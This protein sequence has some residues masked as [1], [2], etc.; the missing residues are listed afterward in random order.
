MARTKACAHSFV[1]HLILV[2]RHYG[3]RKNIH[4]DCHIFPNSISTKYFFPNFVLKKYKFVQFYPYK[5][6]FSILSLRNINLTYFCHLIKK[7]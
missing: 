5:F 6:F 3:S 2:F 1:L 4:F 7:Y